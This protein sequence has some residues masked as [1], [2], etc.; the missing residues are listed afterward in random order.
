MKLAEAAA[1][2]IEEG[3][4]LVGW[5]HLNQLVAAFGD[6]G[7]S[8]YVYN[9]KG[10]LMFE[11]RAGDLEVLAAATRGGV[12]VRGQRVS[13]RFSVRVL[14]EADLVLALSELD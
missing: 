10:A 14:A 2:L 5:E 6:C 8:P 7:I 13:E 1:Q 12:A 4:G 3:G 9:A 11:W